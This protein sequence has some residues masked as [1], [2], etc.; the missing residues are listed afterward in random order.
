MLYVYTYVYAYLMN[1][2]VIDLI[3]FF[4]LPFSRYVYVCPSV[5]RALSIASPIGGYL[6]VVEILFNAL[7]A[8]D[9]CHAAV[10]LFTSLQS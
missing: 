5:L 8:R 1:T 6:V 7:L 4:S 3:Q 9:A 2:Y 10:N